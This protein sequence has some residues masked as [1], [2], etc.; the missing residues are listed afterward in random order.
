M[1]SFSVG[2]SAVCC[3]YSYRGLTRNIP[4]SYGEVLLEI[5]RVVLQIFHLPMSFLYIPEGEK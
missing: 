4:D 2:Y 5:G 1:P 3:Q